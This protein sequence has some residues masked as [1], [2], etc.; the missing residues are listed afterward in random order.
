MHLR[1]SITL[2]TLAASFHMYASA[3]AETIYKQVDESGSV[4]FSNKPGKNST[5]A[6]LPEIA[7]SK[8]KLA[9]T[10]L[11]TC[12]SHGGINCEAGP[13]PS[14]SVICFDGFQGAAARFIFSCSSA[15]L[16][17]AQ[18]A[19]IT[20]EESFSVI[21]RNVK[22]VAAEAPELYLKVDGTTELTLIG[23][24]EI[25]PFGAGEFVLDIKDVGRL[26]STPRKQDFRL[27]CKN[28]S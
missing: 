6:D 5:P 4:T 7:R 25:E 10:T 17:I 20:K 16:E 9:E 28:C 14:G 22:S 1:L 27:L 21:V 15:K 3:T 18:I 26:S 2:L 13:S 24:A 12:D 11:A 23:P 19:D 8:M